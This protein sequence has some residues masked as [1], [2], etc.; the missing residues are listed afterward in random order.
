VTNLVDGGSQ[1]NATVSITSTFTAPDTDG[2]GIHD[3]YETANGLNL[4]SAADA[5]QDMDGDG[6][7]N[8]NEYLGG[9]NP[10]IHNSN[11][12]DIPLPPWAFALLVISL[13]HAGDKIAYCCLQATGR[14]S[15]KQLLLADMARADMLVPAP[16]GARKHRR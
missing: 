8:L 12:N 11:G 10:R 4:N 1:G 6:V 5:S 16:G 15:L 3:A 7:S 14:P 13:T 9:T 2:D